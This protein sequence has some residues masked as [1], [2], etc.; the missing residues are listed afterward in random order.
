M[1]VVILLA[2]IGLGLSAGALLLFAHSMRN[3]VDQH[4]DRLALLPI[5]DDAPTRKPTNDHAQ[6]R[7]GEG[8]HAARSALETQ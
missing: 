3:R 8:V 4:A 1:E 2:F 5:D 6:H 7:D